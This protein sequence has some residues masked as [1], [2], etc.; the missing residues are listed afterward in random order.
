LWS[1]HQAR[2]AVFARVLVVLLGGASLLWGVAGIATF[3]PQA[4][5]ERVAQRIVNREPFEIDA[6]K[7]LAPA[8]QEIEL[9]AQCRPAAMRSVAIIRLRLAEAALAD[10]ERS[11][12][13]DRLDALRDSISRA[14]ACSPADSFL[15][16]VRYWL[17][18]TRNGFSPRNFELL[19]MSYR[20]G[21][22]EGWV[23]LRR[24]R[25]A[26]SVF[27]ALP[28]DLAENAIVEF[29]GLLDS[30]F[31][32]DVVQILT[33]PA[34]PVRDLILPRLRQVAEFRRQLLASALYTEGWDV[35][36]PGVE[37]PA[38]RPWH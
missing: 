20:V 15:W 18:G 38:A 28:A 34:W 12:V 29:V 3:S 6:L 22:R 23:A 2:R 14:L 9:A 25:L 1:D 37:A 27:A 16:L 21:P 17:E 31:Y 4:P 10:G 13:D 7:A 35:A 5:I 36:I 33:G 24:N 8:M 26:F 11:N 30:S 32:A 19:R